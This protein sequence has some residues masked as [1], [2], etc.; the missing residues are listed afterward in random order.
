MVKFTQLGDKLVAYSGFLLRGCD[1][2]TDSFL[3]L[4]ILDTSVRVVFSS[5]Y[6]ENSPGL[7][8]VMTSGWK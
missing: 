4:L 1:G 6:P 7:L 5:W 8:P 2:T 3:L